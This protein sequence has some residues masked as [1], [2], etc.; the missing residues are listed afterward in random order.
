MNLKPYADLFFEGTLVKNPLFMTGLVISPAV[1]CADTFRG[2]LTAALCFSLITAVTSGIIS[3]FPAQKIIYTLRIILYTAAAACV[4]GLVIWGAE[5]IF[6]A[7]VSEFLVFLQCMCVNS[8]ILERFDKRHIEGKRK[9]LF[10]IVS[11]V[12]GFDIAILIFAA[13]RE[14]VSYGTFYGNTVSFNTP[15]PVFG[16]VFGGFIMLG[17][18]SGVFRLILSGLGLFD[19]S[20]DK[21]SDKSSGKSSEKTVPL[22]GGGKAV[23]T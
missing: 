14:I 7:E 3:L 9:K 18:V 22:E 10:F 11:A 8:L 16:Y 2:G 13:V 4:C 5:Q 23:E 21:S 17:I 15:L 20:P 12:I 1:F 19:K 6:A